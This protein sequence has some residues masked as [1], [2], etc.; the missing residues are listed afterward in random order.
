MPVA[1]STGRTGTSSRIFGILSTASGEGAGFAQRLTPD[2]DA[3][4]GPEGLVRRAGVRRENA[5]CREALQIVLGP[6]GN[7]NVEHPPPPQPEKAESPAGA[8]DE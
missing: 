1:A 3:M 8:L 6:G 4:L 2:A 5:E 7:P